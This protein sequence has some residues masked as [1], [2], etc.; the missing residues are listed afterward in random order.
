MT[1]DQYA[2]TASSTSL[3][4]RLPEWVLEGGRE[5][6]KKRLADPAQRARAAKEMKESIKRG[7]FKDFSYAVVA[8]YQPKPEY[9]GKSIAEITKLARG[10]KDVAQPDRADA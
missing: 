7:G 6:G 1:V 5:E 3:D 4:S 9:N 2:Y 10:K 8:S